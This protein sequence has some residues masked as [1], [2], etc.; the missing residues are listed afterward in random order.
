[1]DKVIE[2]TNELK[3]EITLLPEYKEFI[4]I[5]ELL[6]KSKELQ[7]IQ[8]KLNDKKITQVE[9]EKLEKEYKNHPLV[10]NYITS[11]DELISILNNVKNILN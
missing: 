4:K 5:K 6:Q 9:K 8:A 10:I 7:E 11:R 1:M 3:E 2:L